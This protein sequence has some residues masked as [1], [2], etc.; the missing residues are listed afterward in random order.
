MLKVAPSPALTALG[1][2]RAE[3]S[4]SS[5][6]SCSSVFLEECLRDWSVWFKP[7][8]RLLEGPGSPFLYTDRSRPTALRRL[9]RH[10]AGRDLLSPSYPPPKKKLLDRAI[11]TPLPFT[12]ALYPLKVLA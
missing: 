8:P 2:D 11:E 12:G 6:R 9:V 1:K 5:R 4:R 3:R 10:A 7:R